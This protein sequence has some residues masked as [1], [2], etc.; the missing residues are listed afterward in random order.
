MTGARVRI[1]LFGIDVTIN[2]K[3]KSSFT[4]KDLGHKEGIVLG[5]ITK[6]YRDIFNVTQYGTFMAQEETQKTWLVVGC[7]DGSVTECLLENATYI[8]GT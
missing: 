2:E 7:E 5:V 1:K 4:G 3:G 8:A 6:P